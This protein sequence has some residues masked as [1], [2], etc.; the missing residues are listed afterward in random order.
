ME[1]G[2]R[3]NGRIAGPFARKAVINLMSCGCASTNLRTQW[4][5]PPSPGW[6]RLW[7]HANRPSSNASHSSAV[8]AQLYAP[9]TDAGPAWQKYDVEVTQA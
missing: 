5:R 8:L 1:Q 3:E 9:A 4:A 2:I 6:S 7:R